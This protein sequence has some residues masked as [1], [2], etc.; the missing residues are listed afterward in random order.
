SAAPIAW[1]GMVFMG[2]F[3]AERACGCIVAAL[4]AATGRL[5]WSFPLVPTGNAPGADT[6]P[7]DAHAGGG[8]I[9]TSLTLDRDTG[10]LSVPTGHPAPDFSGAY[11]P[12]ANLYTGSVVVLDAKTGALRTWYQLVPHDTHD[13]DVAATPSFVTPKLR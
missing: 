4:D 12:G 3:G 2:T 11:R 6:W 10:E 9:W 1:N 7:K 5:L 8:S 13:W